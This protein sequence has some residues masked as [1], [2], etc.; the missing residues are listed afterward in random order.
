[1]TLVIASTN[2]GKLR[3]FA[4]AAASVDSRVSF[5]PL[6]GL[7]EIAAPAED[8]PTFEGNA[9]LKAVYYSRHAPG[10]IMLADDSGLEVEALG[11]AP[12]VRSARYADDLG[13][14]APGTP[15]ERN[16]LCL[17][18]ALAGIGGPHPARYRCV[19]AAAR[20]G[21]VLCTAHG[22]VE[23][24]I[25][26]SPR[27]SEGFGYDPLFFVPS[28]QKTMAEL[29]ATT[30]LSFSHRGRALRSLLATLRDQREVV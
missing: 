3:D 7:E 13:F 15:D 5:A 27:G 6:P 10:R 18:Q 11:G 30:K 4:A 17:Q 19:L 2:P 1:M 29:D 22:M 14:V 28:L 26:L 16:N 23:G 21:E 12:G 24:E 8:Q 9:R 20:E 25:L